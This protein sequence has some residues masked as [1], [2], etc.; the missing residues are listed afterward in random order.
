MI[1]E[2]YSAVR[3]NSFLPAFGQRAQVI[4]VPPEKPQW[5]LKGQSHEILMA[6]L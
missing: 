3:V 1:Y 2:E 4:L 6:F 5:R